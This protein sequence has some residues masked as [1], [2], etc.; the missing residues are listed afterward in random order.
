MEVKIFSIVIILL[1]LSQKGVA[2]LSNFE[3]M[4][5]L[6]IHFEECLSWKEIKEKAKVE[7]KYIFIDVYASWCGPCKRMEQEVYPSETL[8]NYWNSKF[9]SVKVQMDSTIHDNEYVR[10]WY[11][12]AHS[13]EKEFRID[14]YPSFLFFD[15]SGKLVFKDFGYKNASDLIIVAEKS[16]NP[17]NVLYYTQLEDY[18]K[19]NKHFNNMRNL[20]LFAKEIIGDTILAKQIANEY[21]KGLNK[22]DILNKGNI[23]LIRDVI[24]NIELANNLAIKYKNDSLNNMSNAEVCSLENLNFFDAFFK[25]LNSSDKIFKLC[26]SNSAEINK[27]KNEEGWAESIVKF[28]VIREELQN[29][30][31]KKGIQVFKNPNW[32]KFTSIIIKKYPKVNVEK[33]VLEYQIAY[34]RKFKEWTEWAKFQDIRIKQLNVNA[35]KPGEAFWELNLPAWDVFLYCSDK[36][37]LVKALEWSELSIKIDKNNSND[38]C[39]DTRANLLYKLGRI[40]EA[41]QQEKEAIELSNQIAKKMGKDKG[42]LVDSYFAALDKMRNSK[43]TWVID[44]KKK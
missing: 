36:K 29:K 23:L 7:N 12:D 25:I 11:D 42:Y 6:G 33:L 22:E 32:N 43:P 21:I 24:G 1:G 16:F 3:N 35:F 41:I 38:Q 4:K 44:K 37:I 18:K 14:A 19:G 39:L 5:S 13:I 9:V 30:L 17:Q 28:T 27:I 31:T 2:Q 40:D 15:P 8:G 26:Y 20:S 34:Y 10:R